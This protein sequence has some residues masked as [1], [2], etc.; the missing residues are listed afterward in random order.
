VASTAGAPCFRH[1]SVSDGFSPHKLGWY[2]DAIEVIGVN[3]L[4][5]ARY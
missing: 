5:I 4:C 1:L 3:A 2:K